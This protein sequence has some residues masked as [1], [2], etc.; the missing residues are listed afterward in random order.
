MAR[1]N[2]DCRREPFDH[3]QKEQ[4]MEARVNLEDLDVV[5][6]HRNGRYLAKIPRIGL[7]ATADSL[8]KAIEALEAKKQ[9]LREEL[10]QAGALDEISAPWRPEQR[11]MIA[12]LALF[13]AKV[14][15]LLVVF[16][17]AVVYTGRMFDRR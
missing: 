8:P 3:S 9:S 13:S 7:Y 16:M 11:G 15:I 5:V 6:R 12:A 4:A 2:P 17:V 14:L 1:A 10:S